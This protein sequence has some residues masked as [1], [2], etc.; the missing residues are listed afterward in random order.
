MSTGHRGSDIHD[1][2]GGKPDRGDVPKAFLLVDGDRNAD[3]LVIR[4]LVGEQVGEQR[5]CGGVLA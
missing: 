2:R 4:S 1:L 3:L 5:D